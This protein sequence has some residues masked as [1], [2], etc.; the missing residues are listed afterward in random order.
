VDKKLAANIIWPPFPAAPAA[1]GGQSWPTLTCL[2][3][4]KTKDDEENKFWWPV[5]TDGK[6][7]EH[8]RLLTFPRQEIPPLMHQAASLGV[9]M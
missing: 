4:V 9:E 2:H 6:D 7:V 1:A 8:D 3:K 5:L